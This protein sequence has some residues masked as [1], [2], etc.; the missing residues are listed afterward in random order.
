MAKRGRINLKDISNSSCYWKTV[1]Y[2]ILR[3]YEKFILFQ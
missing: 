3:N 1:N 2:C